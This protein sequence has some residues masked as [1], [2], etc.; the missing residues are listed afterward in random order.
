VTAERVPRLAG[1]IYGTILVLAVIGALS[2][3][4]E[5]GSGELLA[6]VLTTSVVFWLAHIYADVIAQRLAGVTGTVV[7]HV[8]EAASHEWPLVEA[9]LAPSAP[10]LLGAVGILSRSTAVNLALAVGLADLFAWGYMAGRA[11]QESRL[12]ALVSALIA[13][14]IGT[15]MVLLKG[16]LH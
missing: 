12:A 11:S 1:A 5:V 6:A 4:D 3:D 16:L 14:V 15:V 8:R 10:L 2:E 7:A 9:A 13:V